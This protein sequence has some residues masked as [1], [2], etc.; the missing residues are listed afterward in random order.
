MEKV[1]A[2]NLNEWY[3]PGKNFS[4]LGSLTNVILQ[5]AFVIA[6]IIALVLLI[7][8]G[9]RFIV[10]AGNGDTKQMDEGK[11][12]IT[13]AVA[14]LIIIIVSVWIVQIIETLTG[15]KILPK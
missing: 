5:N 7:F 15:I 14:G 9:F 13:G 6:G 3:S 1:N 12:A 11:K 8:A 2:V 10:A 4:N